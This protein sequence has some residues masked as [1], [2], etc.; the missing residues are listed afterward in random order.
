MSIPLLQV[1]HHVLIRSM[2]KQS[3]WRLGVLIER[4]IPE[5]ILN[6]GMEGNAEEAGFEVTPKG[7]RVEKRARV[8]TGEGLHIYGFMERRGQGA[9]YRH[10]LRILESVNKS[11]KFG[12]QRVTPCGSLNQAQ[13]DERKRA[14]T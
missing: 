14:Q 12:K 9:T 7:E 1:G 4:P 2:L 11:S 10:G 5:G 13:R 6:E 8:E 3:D